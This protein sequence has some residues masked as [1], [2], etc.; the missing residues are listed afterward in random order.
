MAISRSRAYASSGCKDD[1]NEVFAYLKQRGIISSTTASSLKEAARRMH[2]Y[3]YSLMIWRFILK[4]PECGQVFIEEVASDALQILPQALM[5]YR[6]TSVLLIRGIVENVLRHIFFRDHPIEF[7]RMNLEKRW[8]PPMKE[9][10]DYLMHHPVFR[11]T[12]RKFDAINR[13]KVLYDDLSSNVHGRRVAHLEM[14]RSLMEIR[15]QKE[16]FD[17]LIKLLHRCV[18]CCNF[19]FLNFHHDQVRACSEEWRQ[20]L[21][22]GIPLNA[23]RVW[24]G[25]T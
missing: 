10:F 25:I 9:L 19:L 4:N 18:E 23:R 3:T 5:G 8:Y 20:L 22:S 11:R 6:K 1:F 12:E 21:V 16:T 2:S 13:F 24:M 17:L 7:E 14:R 15:Y